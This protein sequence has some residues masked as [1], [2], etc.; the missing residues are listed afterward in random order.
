MCNTL[1]V[2]RTELLKKQTQQE[3][4]KAAVNLNEAPLETTQQQTA[5]TGLQTT[6]VLNSFKLQIPE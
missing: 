2:K 5:Q 1:E 4:N 3:E 6:R